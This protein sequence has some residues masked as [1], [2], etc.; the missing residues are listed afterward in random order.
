M[1]HLLRLLAQPACCA[2]DRVPG[3]PQQILTDLNRQVDKAEKAT[4]ASPGQPVAAATDAA[5]AD[6]AIKDDLKS[7]GTGLPEPARVALGKVEASVKR[8]QELLQ[9][10]PVDA[11]AVAAAAADFRRDAAELG[12][13]LGN[14]NG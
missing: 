5:E 7:L 1:F 6:R 8:V 13:L 3:T 14:G 10:Q 2:L 12:K 4:A 9:K 11:K